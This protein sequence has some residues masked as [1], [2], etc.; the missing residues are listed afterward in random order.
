MDGVN[1][2]QLV[3]STLAA[4]MIAAPLVV[5]A[6]V[7]GRRSNS[8]ERSRRLDQLQPDLI[9]GGTTWRATFDGDADPA[10][11]LTVLF[12]FEQFDSR[13]VASGRSPDG[14][15][16]SLEG[17]IHRGRLCCVSIDENSAGAW[18]GTITAELNAD[19]LM[20]GMRT[21]WTP[22]SQ[23]LM[24]RKVVFTRLDASVSASERLVNA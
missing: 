17:V 3:V 4:V 2:A 12:A 10:L 24:V 15:E 1:L 16:H 18:L 14:T 8:R 22:V 23:T 13:I 5:M 21:R 7:A 6:Y 11:R 9:L 20:T 19:T